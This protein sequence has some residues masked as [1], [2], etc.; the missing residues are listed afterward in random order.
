MSVLSN[1]KIQLL[2]A[3]IVF[4]VAMSVISSM[5]PTPT[6][7]LIG[8]PKGIQLAKPASEGVRSLPSHQPTPEDQTPDN[9]FPNPEPTPRTKGVCCIDVGMPPM[10]CVDGYSDVPCTDGGYFVEGTDCPLS[11]EAVDPCV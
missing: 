8:E 11:R 1:H 4:L 7:Q 3:A 2:L 9:P 10:L 5:Q 6:A